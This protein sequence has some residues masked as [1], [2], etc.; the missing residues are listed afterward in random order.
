M[1]YKRFFSYNYWSF[2][3]GN[4][5]QSES[6]SWQSTVWFMGL[7]FCFNC[8]TVSAIIAGFLK[9]VIF[10]PIIFGLLW[11]LPLACYYIYF[12]YILSNGKKRMIIRTNNIPTGWKWSFW[13]YFVLSKIG[14]IVG[15]TIYADLMY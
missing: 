14:M 11:V 7:V 4:S 13:L 5:P 10:H 9:F 2:R 12:N 1:L 8:I 3:Y 15:L 6:A